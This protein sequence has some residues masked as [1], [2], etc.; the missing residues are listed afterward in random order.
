MASFAQGAL[1]LPFFQFT[2]DHLGPLAFLRR[3][4]LVEIGNSFSQGR[5]NPL[6]T[7]VPTVGLAF[8]LP[9]LFTM[10]RA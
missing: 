10:Q 9:R 3:T 6:S 2:I 1:S 5:A 8:S 7:P 4:A